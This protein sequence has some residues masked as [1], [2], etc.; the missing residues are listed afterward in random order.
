MGLWALPKKAAWLLIVA[1]FTSVHWLPVS[2]PSKTASH[3]SV[4]YSAQKLA[5]LR[6]QGKTVFLDFTADW[7]ATCKVNEKVAIDPVLPEFA[8]HNAVYMVGDWTNNDAA[9][10]AV[11]QQ[12]NRAGVPLYVVYRGNAE[13]DVLPQTLTP[14]L[15][16]KAISSPHPQGS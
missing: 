1:S 3:S 13:A 5:E 7:C 8:Q 12:F 2:T 16:R 9:I 14:S 4:P 15:V 11:L 6:Q 10:T